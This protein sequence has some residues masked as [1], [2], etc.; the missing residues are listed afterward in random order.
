MLFQFMDPLIYVLTSVVSL[1]IS[2]GKYSLLWRKMKQ[3]S[4][5]ENEGG[6][7]VGSLYLFV[8]RVCILLIIVWSVCGK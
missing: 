1:V 3:P 2:D 6:N 5:I 8:F 7:F 4:M